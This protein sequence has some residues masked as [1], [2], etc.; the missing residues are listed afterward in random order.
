M[1]LELQDDN[2]F[3]RIFFDLLKYQLTRGS[4][5]LEGMSAAADTVEKSMNVYN[6]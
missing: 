4:L 3:K 5:Q 2:A 6:L 1:F